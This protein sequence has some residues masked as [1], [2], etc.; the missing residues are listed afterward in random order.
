MHFLDL[1]GGAEA[2]GEDELSLC[3][4]AQTTPTVSR[5]SFLPSISMRSAS[6]S[7][8]T[9]K[10]ASRSLKADSTHSRSLST[11]KTPPIE[12]PLV[13]R[14]SK[15]RKY[16]EISSP[17]QRS[18]PPSK[19]KHRPNPH[20]P[21]LPI[22][23]SLRDAVRALPT[24]PLSTTPSLPPM[25]SSPSSKRLTSDPHKTLSSV[26]I[27]ERKVSKEAHDITTP[28]KK[29]KAVS[30]S[31][32]ERK[33][34]DVAKEKESVR[35]DF[36]SERKTIPKTQPFLFKRAVLEFERPKVLFPARDT[37]LLSHR[38]HVSS[39]TVKSAASKLATQEEDEEEGSEFEVPG[40]EE[41]E[42]D[43]KEEDSDW[44]P[45]ESEEEEEEDSRE[46]DEDAN[47]D[48]EAVEQDPDN[49]EEG[50]EEG[51]SD[52]AESIT[53]RKSKSN[54]PSSTRTPTQIARREATI[55]PPSKKKKRAVRELEDALDGGWRLEE[56]KVGEKSVREV[57]DNYGEEDEMDLIGPSP[58]KL[59]MT[60]GRMDVGGSLSA[61]RM[62][63][64]RRRKSVFSGA[65]GNSLEF[66]EEAGES[67]DP[68]S[69][70]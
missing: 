35:M 62:E 12:S 67:D 28:V 41:E 19:H 48:E 38:E 7:S 36:M 33:P 58:P 50:P 63:R 14:T 49:K 47:Y 13:S 24:P 68:L 8:K 44:Q 11:R 3:S 32:S 54:D 21:S 25:R 17:T 69:V 5:T 45:D 30:L 4:S 66:E 52:G 40:E 26:S 65:G 70:L 6:I 1:G 64:E 56:T 23:L 10:S 61:R 57:L 46:A 34:S 27:W 60:P 42:E 22:S 55:T 15:K 31:L 59:K 39:F 53:P 20:S 51:K 37:S 18:S 43:V 29:D 2:D 9:P 16:G